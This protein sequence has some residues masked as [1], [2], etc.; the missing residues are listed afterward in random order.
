MRDEYNV[1]E[2]NSS[3]RRSFYEFIKNVGAFIK[4]QSIINL[5]LS[6][7]HIKQTQHVSL[8]LLAL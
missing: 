3:T 1:I 4:Q 5:I 6:Y 7:V 2:L 8:T